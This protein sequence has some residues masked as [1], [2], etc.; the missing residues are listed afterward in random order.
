MQ[1]DV[2]RGI[3]CDFFKFQKIEDSQV[4]CIMQS[5]HGIMKSFSDWGSSYI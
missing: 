3:V 1:K 2:H 5:L 4:Y